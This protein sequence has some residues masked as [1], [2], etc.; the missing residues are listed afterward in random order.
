M[1]AS[2]LIFL[3]I[4]AFAAGF[5]CALA[6]KANA[7]SS[8]ISSANV[9]RI[10]GT[11]II[12]AFPTWSFNIPLSPATNFMAA[13]STSPG[14]SLTV[15]NTPIYFE[16]AA[17][18]GTG[19][20]TISSELSTTTK[21]G[22]SQIHLSW[23]AVPGASA[24]FVYF[25]TTTPSGENAYFKATTTNAYDF[26][27]TSSPLFGSAPGFPSS[28]A[29]QLSN[30]ATPLTVNGLPFSPIATTTSPIGGS[31]L[32]TGQCATATSTLLIGTVSSST[33]VMTTPQK[34]PGPS[35]TWQSYVL[36]PTQIVTQVCALLAGTPVSTTYNVRAF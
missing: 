21:T 29:V 1:S 36:G 30:G 27:S 6:G 10:G 4:V 20:T 23:T 2:K 33:V 32:S 8:T 28:F 18:T 14:G 34:F 35:V 24:Y 25:S 3:A 9:L 7:L 13:S 22:S 17:T 5:V 19:T 16:V 31:A 11:Q 12:P 15:S 26:T